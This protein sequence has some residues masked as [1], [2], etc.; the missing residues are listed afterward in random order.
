MNINSFSTKIFIGNIPY[1]YQESELIET[2]EMV[3]P[4]RGGLDIKKDDRTGKPKG[5]GF[6][7]Y[8]DQESRISALKNLKSIEY[9]GR[10]LEVNTENNQKHTVISEDSLRY[11]RDFS[12]IKEMFSSLSELTEE[13]KSFLFLI[14]KFLND[15]YPNEFE[16]LLYNQEESFLVDFLSFQEEFLNKLQLKDS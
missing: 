13:Q 8:K 9:N 6:C 4:L 7:E 12:Y 11:L 16:E 5:F 2:L 10:Q 3:G 15:N 1:D 14:T